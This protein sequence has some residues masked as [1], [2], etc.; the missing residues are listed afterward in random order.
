MPSENLLCGQESFQKTQESGRSNLPCNF[1]G[2]FGGE[3]FLNEKRE[4]SLESFSAF[5]G[6]AARRLSETTRIV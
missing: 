2:E 6:K 1:A 3:Q 5:R 4:E